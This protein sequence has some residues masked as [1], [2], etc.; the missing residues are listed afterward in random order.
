MIERSSFIPGI[1]LGAALLIASSGSAWAQDKVVSV[2]TLDCPG[3]A[4]SSEQVAAASEV[5]ILFLA[6]F[7]SSCNRSP[8]RRSPGHRSRPPC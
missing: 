4:L 2:S 3:L 8:R 5:T 7:L 6:R 1:V